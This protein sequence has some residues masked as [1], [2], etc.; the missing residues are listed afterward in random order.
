M[1]ELKQYE[2]RINGSRQ[3]IYYGDTL[4][5]WGTSGDEVARRLRQHQEFMVQTLSNGTLHQYDLI[6][7][8]G[9]STVWQICKQGEIIG[10]ARSI[11]DV[12]LMIE[13]HKLGNPPKQY[14]M[15]RKK[16]H[17]EGHYFR[18]Y[19]IY[20]KKDRQLLGSCKNVYHGIMVCMMHQKYLW[21]N[22]LI[23][24][25]SDNKW[26]VRYDTKKKKNPPFFG[27]YD[28]LQTAV[29]TIVTSERIDEETLCRNR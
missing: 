15:E 8:P 27:P 19:K 26:I 23:V 5:V 7:K 28:A 6:T 2:F 20:V 17:E 18:D 9:L 21:K 29:S 22:M 25:F 24:A 11:N 16:R 14:M 1:E 4:V 10:E 12:L 13:A 3:E